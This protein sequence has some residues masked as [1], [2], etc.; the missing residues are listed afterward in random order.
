MCICIAGVHGQTYEWG[1]KFNFDPQT[2]TDPRFV[3]KDNYNHYLLTVSNSDG[4]LAKRQVTI[5]KFDQKNQ[6]LETF[7]QQ[8][9]KFDMNTL[10]NYLG[11]AES[12]GAIA[13][14][15]HDYS[16]KA[17]KEAIYSNQFDK[18]TAKFTSTEI[19]SSEI[20]SA[21]KS[22]DVALQKSDN[23]R[24]IGI[25]Y[26][27]YQAKGETEKVQ[28]LV[29]DSYTLNIVWK[30]EFA[31]ADNFTLKTFAVTNSG[32]LVFLRSPKS[33]KEVNYMILASADGQEEK[34][35]ETN[36]VLQSIK[37]VSIGSQDYIVAFNYPAKT[38]RTGSDFSNLLLY[39][40]KSGRA[41]QN[42]KIP[43]FDDVK[44]LTEVQ[45]QKIY[46]QNN[47][48]H[49][50][51][52]A[53]SRG[54][55]KPGMPGAFSQSSY[56][57]TFTFGPAHLIITSMDGTVKSIQKLLVDDRSKA[58]LYHSFGV[59]NLRGKYYINTGEYNNMYSLDGS[60]NYNRAEIGFIN[61]I[62]NEP[63]RDQKV[64]F[65][66]QLVDYLP[67]YQQLFLGRII[68]E[69]EMALLTVTGVK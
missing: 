6:L 1:S 26:T 51:T 38:L 43:V 49:L 46:F 32:K 4:M 62:Q 24:Y 12:K 36:L 33:T 41:L 16:G 44:N 30:K 17:K 23:D 14:F 11:F 69:K 22:A 29:L 57:Q 2:E 45:M 42:S 50:F 61:L 64:K 65:V 59:V 40:L 8:F 25:T 60:N 27:P 15:T 54:E 13:V 9:P 48:I 63:F 68:N 34:R 7:I 31:F 66:N 37:S 18:A 58:N 3:L 20:L 53:K 55:F 56:G 67:E 28:A 39:D 52:E 19:I 35:L 47:E 5:R 21:S 10:H